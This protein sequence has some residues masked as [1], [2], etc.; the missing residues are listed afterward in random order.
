[1]EKLSTAKLKTMISEWLSKPE[2]RQELDHHTDNYSKRDEKEYLD[3]LNELWEY[4]ANSIE[5]MN[6]HIWKLWCDGYQWKRAEKRQLKDEWED[7]LAESDYDGFDYNQPRPWNP[8]LKP[9][10]LIDMLGEVNE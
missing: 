5:E 2:Y 10:F 1:M 4:K 7:K 6:D 3:R 9:A 8:K